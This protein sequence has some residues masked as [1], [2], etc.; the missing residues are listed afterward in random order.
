MKG[1]CLTHHGWQ[2]KHD[3]TKFRADHTLPEMVSGS[4][5]MCVSHSRDSL[6]FL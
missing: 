5:S 6:A 1:M 4:V 2:A 3:P